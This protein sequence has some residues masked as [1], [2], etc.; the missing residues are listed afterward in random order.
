MTPITVLLADDHTIVREGFR[1]LLELENDITVVG[2]AHHGREAVEMAQ[3]LKPAVIVM[4]IAM[5]LLN[6]ISA[7]QQILAVLPAT[8]VL[9]LSAYSDDPYIHRVLEVGAAGFLV[10]QS[11]AQCL[12]RAIREVSAGR[13]FFSPS[14]AKRIQAW[15]R[16]TSRVG[17]VKS[18]KKLTAR[19]LEVIQRI[20]EGAT[21]KEIAY[22]LKISVK[23][24]EK[25]RQHLMDKLDIHDTAGLTRYAIAHGIIESIIQVTIV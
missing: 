1:A 11:S 19:E 9:I 23:T 3:K 2:E 13:K 14:V 10:K 25:H 24:V 17:V 18:V 16:D 22:G 5:P 21:N 4:D 8:K 6:G 20:A 15:S 7:T 12:S